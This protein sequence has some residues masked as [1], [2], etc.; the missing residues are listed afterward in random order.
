MTVYKIKICERIAEFRPDKNLLV[1]A[2][3][4]SPFSRSLMSTSESRL[5]EALI[6]EPGVTKTRDELL[7]YAW[8]NRVVSPGSLNQ[9]IFNIRNLLGK[10]GHDAI[11]TVP[12]KGYRFNED[13]IFIE[14]QAA[15][16]LGK[17]LS[18][19]QDF[20]IKRL[21]ESVEVE[22]LGACSGQKNNSTI[23]AGFFYVYRQYVFVLA[24]M[25]VLLAVI[26][27]AYIDILPLVDQTYK[28]W[29]EQNRCLST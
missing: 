4:D 2:D 18:S 1:W 27:F 22:A 9:C 17:N 16:Q 11:Q 28:I 24:F 19:V 23:G 12:R 14:C 29:F 21:G 8:E 3:S 20:D 5:L 7:M 6:K 13:Y 10:N 15:S 25:L 26:S